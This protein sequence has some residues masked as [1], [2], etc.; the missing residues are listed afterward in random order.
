MQYL[1][2]TK[3]TMLSADSRKIKKGGAFLAVQG[4]Q[5][6]G[7]DFI[8]MALANGASVIITHT[9]TD[10]SN[11]PKGIEVISHD[12][13]RA[14]F[15]KMA[16]EFYQPQPTFFGAVTGTNGK[17]SIANFVQQFWALLNHKSIAIGTMGMTGSGYEPTT[18][19]TTPDPVDLHHALQ[20]A[21]LDKNITHVCLE[22]SS[23]GLHMQ[24]ID[25][26]TVKAAGF[27]NLSRDHLDYHENMEQYFTAKAR[28]FSHILCERGLGVLHKNIPEFEALKAICHSR[29]INILSY[30]IKSGADLDITQYTR[31]PTGFNITIQYMGQAIESSVR[32]A[33]VFQLENILCAI[34]I[35]SS[36]GIDILDLIALLPKIKG[37]KGRLEYIGTS[38]KGAD[39]F[40]DFAHTPAALESVLKTMRPHATNNLCVVIGC[41]GDRDSGKRP[42]MGKISVELADVVYITDD[43]PRTEDAGQIRTNMMV[44]AIGA[45][46]IAGRASAIKNAIKKLEKGDILIVAGKGHEQGQIIGTTVHPFDDGDCIKTVLETL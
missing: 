8:P 42:I 6:N 18:S 11:I 17:T 1:P 46:E 25:G 23:H 3:I 13:P 26:I 44:G 5:S 32:L 34:G 14:I 37:V 40:V 30:G 12:N 28:L 16:N 20:N 4:V 15:A 24:R 39:I 27:T 29:N 31:T 9:Q 38:T 45:T 35:A 33:G 43:N 19:L 10:T 22:A 2:K 41:G 21:T 7:V 36:A